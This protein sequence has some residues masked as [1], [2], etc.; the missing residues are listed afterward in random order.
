[1]LEMLTSMIFNFFFFGIFQRTPVNMTFFL[2]G[3]ERIDH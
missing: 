3:F 2:L 1:M